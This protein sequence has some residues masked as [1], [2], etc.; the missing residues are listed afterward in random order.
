[1][2]VPGGSEVVE[3]KKQVPGGQEQWVAFWLFP[4]THASAKYFEISG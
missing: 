3:W 4:C 1:M 2:Y